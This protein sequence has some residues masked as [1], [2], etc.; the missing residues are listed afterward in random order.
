MIC[1]L[2]YLQLCQ[3]VYLKQELYFYLLLGKS[4]LQ[5]FYVCWS[6]LSCHKGQGW[7]RPK[8]L[9]D[10]PSGSGAVVCFSQV[11]SRNLVGIGEPV[12]SGCSFICYATI[13]GPQNVI[14][15]LAYKR[16]EIMMNVL[17]HK[18]VFLYSEIFQI[19]IGHTKNLTNQK[20]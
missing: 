19:F 13:P 12:T 14:F 10:L 1:I 18:W 15:F 16:L 7:S 4:E 8:P 17:K 9:S 2:K 5:Q 20:F 11:I 6:L 3:S